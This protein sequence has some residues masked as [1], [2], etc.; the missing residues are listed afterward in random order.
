MHALKTHTQHAQIM[1]LFE[2]GISHSSRY[3]ISPIARGDEWAPIYSP[4]EPK[5][6]F[7]KQEIPY[8]IQQ[9]LHLRDRHS[10]ACGKTLQTDTVSLC[11]HD[12]LF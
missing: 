12:D 4:G 6:L 8:D 5:P 2:G 1:V 3:L 11:R 10:K 7:G 9:C